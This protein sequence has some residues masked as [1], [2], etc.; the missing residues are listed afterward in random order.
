MSLYDSITSSG[1]RVKRRLFDRRIESLGRTVRAV[2]IQYRED[3]YQNLSDIDMLSSN[4]ISAIVRFSDD[5]PLNRYR[6]DRTDYTED[7]RTFFFDLLPVEVF[8]KLEDSIELRD[9]LFFW[10]LDENGN[11][12]PFLLQVTEVFGRFGASLTYKKLLCAP[13]Y[14]ALT[15]PIYG[16]LMDYYMKDDNTSH[17]P[18]LRQEPTSEED[19]P[20]VREMRMSHVKDKENKR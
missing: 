14:G 16:L 19:S 3:M 1:E 17:D 5:I 11:R 7:T 12:I 6:A 9:L 4:E 2:R 13:L 15:K 18:L 20:I 8:T 10:F